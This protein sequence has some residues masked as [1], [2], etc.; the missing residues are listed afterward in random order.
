[1]NLT[2]WMNNTL[3]R[4]G[5]VGALGLSLLLGAAW[6]HHVW[7]AQ[8]LDQAAQAGSEA[9]RLRHALLAQVES[10]AVDVSQAQRVGSPEQ[11]WQTLWQ[12]LP[13]AEQR[14]ALQAEVLSSA[15]ARG[16]QV[17]AVQYKGQRQAWAVREGSALWR[18]RMMMPVEGRYPAVRAWLAHLLTEPALSL[19]ELDIQRPDANSDQVKVRVGVSLWWRQAEGAQP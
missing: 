6:V 5:L 4:M 8:Q 17:Q 2:P 19:D 10:T 13:L 18:Q 12:A 14:V 16:L 3:R 1:M 11:A 9:R 15:Q 7:L